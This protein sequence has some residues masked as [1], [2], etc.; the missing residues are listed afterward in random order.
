MRINIYGDSIMK[1]TVLEPNGRYRSYLA[2]TL[3]EV[4]NKFRL[5]VNNRSRFGSTIGRG[6]S[7]LTADLD[8]GESC[9]CALIEFGGNDCNFNW[10]EVA[11]A[12]FAEHSPNTPLQR[13][14]Q[15]LTD[16]IDRLQA[17]HIKPVLMSLPPI[18]A[19]KYLNFLAHSGIDPQR[20]LTWLGDTQLI[21]RFHEL[22]SN[23]VVSLA[24][25]RNIS[26]IDVRSCFLSRHNY[27]ELISP[28]GL[29]PTPE[30]YAL[31]MEAF[32]RRL[33]EISLV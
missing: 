17:L 25:H 13:F 11:E 31:V 6:F 8:A 30:G 4:A 27:K 3:D 5:S 16:M 29:H 20:L 23:A 22:Y 15:T 26:L 10:K 2:E 21:Y 28:D 18:D 19:E 1:A 24:L 33:T 14:V 12:P 9:D 7:L 32:T